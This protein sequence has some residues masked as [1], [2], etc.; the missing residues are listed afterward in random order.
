MFLTVLHAD[1]RIA[2]T[3][4]RSAAPAT[5]ATA[6]TLPT[7][8]GRAWQVVVDCLQALGAARAAA[9]GRHW[10]VGWLGSP[11]SV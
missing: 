3:A 1:S 6:S 4:S 11:S 5:A 9:S 7:P 8:P 10:I 2:A